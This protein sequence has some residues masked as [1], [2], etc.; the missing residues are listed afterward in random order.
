MHVDTKNERNS[1]KRL[2]K[3]VKQLILLSHAMYFKP[4][5]MGLISNSIH[6]K[7]NKAICLKS[8]L[9]Q[10][11]WSHVTVIELKQLNVGQKLS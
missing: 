11:Q 6:E 4:C 7:P 5:K 9:K 3:L 8:P 1:M 2:K 10:F